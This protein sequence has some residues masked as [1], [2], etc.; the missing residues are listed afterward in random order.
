M[1]V[2]TKGLNHGTRQ[3][4]HPLRS[5][6][7]VRKRKTNGGERERERGLDFNLLPFIIS[8][9]VSFSSRKANNCKLI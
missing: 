4:H 8:K 3:L 5:M 2:V 7:D 1:L 9:M 6:S